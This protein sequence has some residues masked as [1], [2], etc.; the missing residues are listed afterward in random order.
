MGLTVNND[1]YWEEATLALA[2][3]H[4]SPLAWSNWNLETSV[5]VER[6]T[7]EPREKPLRTWARTN[8][9]LNP[10]WQLVGIEPRPHWWEESANHWVNSVPFS[11]NYNYFLSTFNNI[12]FHSTVI[13]LTNLRIKGN[14]F[15]LKSAYVLQPANWVCFSSIQWLHDRSQLTWSVFQRTRTR[16]EQTTKRYMYIPNRLKYLKHC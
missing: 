1:I 2:G 10:L 7:R 3:F 16:R 12:E 8:N 4:V 15:E 6:K 13:I 14:D 9:K 11:F 5:F